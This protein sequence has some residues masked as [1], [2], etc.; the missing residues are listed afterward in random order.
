MQYV[1]TSREAH[2]PHDELHTCTG[3]GQPI[4]CNLA[5]TYGQVPALLI[6]VWLCKYDFRFQTVRA[7]TVRACQFCASATSRGN[8]T[9]HPQDRHNTRLT[10]VHREA[11]PSKHP[12]VRSPRRV[13]A[14]RRRQFAFKMRFHIAKLWLNPAWVNCDQ[15]SFWFQNPNETSFKF[16][17][18]R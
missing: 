4:G 6:G 1:P 9:Q 12:L 8:S 13:R 15:V 7:V 2:S 16:I 11:R 3:Q 14:R 10:A 5:G 17:M 18:S